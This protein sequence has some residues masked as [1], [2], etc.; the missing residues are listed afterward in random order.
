MAAKKSDS[1]SGEL[2]ALAPC[3]YYRTKAGN[4]AQPVYQGGQIPR[5]AVD[6]D[7][8]KMLEDEGIVGT[9]KEAEKAAADDSEA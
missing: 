3:V 8:L 5:D 9:P 6:P 7:H 2:V 1:G 4:F